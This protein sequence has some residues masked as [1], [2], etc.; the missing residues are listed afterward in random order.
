MGEM[1]VKQ[2]VTICD[3]SSFCAPSM[4]LVFV[5]R[6]HNNSNRRFSPCVKESDS[7]IFSLVFVAHNTNENQSLSAFPAMLFS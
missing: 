6:V 2:T 1:T 4:P 3:Y 7:L 5:V